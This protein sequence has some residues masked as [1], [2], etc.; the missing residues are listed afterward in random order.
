MITLKK[1]KAK[2]RRSGGRRGVC[3]TE[4]ALCVNFL[5][6]SSWQRR[7]IWEAGIHHWEETRAETTL[8]TNQELRH[9][10]HC[11]GCSLEPVSPVLRSCFLKTTAAF[12]IWYFLHGFSSSVR[13]SFSEWFLEEPDSILQAFIRRHLLLPCTVCF[14]CRAYLR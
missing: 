5:L 14:F 12:D 9:W 4:H 10:Q 2:N 11:E 6:S 13:S 7:S 1:S 3:H 8:R